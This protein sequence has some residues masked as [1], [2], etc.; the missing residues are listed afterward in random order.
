MKIQKKVTMKSKFKLANKQIGDSRQGKEERLE[1][2]QST[3]QANEKE[4]VGEKGLELANAIQ[5]L[6]VH[7]KT[8][9]SQWLTQVHYT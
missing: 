3:A 9:L 8:R 1:R 5:P 2:C 4:I 6:R 7:L